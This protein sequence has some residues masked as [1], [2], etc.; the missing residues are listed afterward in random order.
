VIGRGRGRGRVEYGGDG[1]GGGG[2]GGEQEAGGGAGAGGE[3]HGLSAG[4]TRMTILM[5]GCAQVNYWNCYSSTSFRL[6]ACCRG[7]TDEQGL[8]GGRTGEGEFRSSSLRGDR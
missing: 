5:E 3:M 2:A 7:G 6:R 4:G 8:V 1:D